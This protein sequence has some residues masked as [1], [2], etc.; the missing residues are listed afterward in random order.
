MPPFMDLMI[1]AFAVMAFAV[2][3]MMFRGERVGTLRCTWHSALRPSTAQI[4][5]RRAAGSREPTI[6][7]QFAVLGAM[8]SVPLDPRQ[9]RQLAE[10]LEGA[11][12]RCQRP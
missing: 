9:A 5:V 1:V 10:I 8:R 3:V 7:L 12:E 6:K 2:F 11:A 4:T